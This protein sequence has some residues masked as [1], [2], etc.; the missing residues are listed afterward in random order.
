LIIRPTANIAMFCEAQT[1]IEPIH[2]RIIS[3]LC[4]ILYQDGRSYSGLIPD[5]CTDLNR[6]FAAKLIREVTRDQS[7]E[8]RATRHGGSNTTLHI[9]LRTVA[10]VDIVSLNLTKYRVRILGSTSRLELLLLT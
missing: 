5:N 8:P 2:L 4:A 1:I 6:T 10:L 9:W 7:T 3:L